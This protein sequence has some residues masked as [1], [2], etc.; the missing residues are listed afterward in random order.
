MP[1]G[2]TEVFEIE[3]GDPHVDFGPVSKLGQASL[4]AL[5]RIGSVSLLGRGIIGGSRVAPDS[6][7]AGHPLCN[8]GR[9][10]HV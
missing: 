2:A 8:P 6:G 4:A 10:L 1:T 3:G 5:V 9:N 7:H